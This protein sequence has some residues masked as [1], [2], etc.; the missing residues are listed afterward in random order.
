MVNPVLLVVAPRFGQLQ[1]ER[2]FE[3][4][5]RSCEAPEQHFVLTEIPS[6]QLRSPEQRVVFIALGLCRQIVDHRVHG[7]HGLREHRIGPLCAVDHAEITVFRIP[8]PGFFQVVVGIFVPRNAD[9]TRDGCSG[10]DIR[11]VPDGAL[12]LRLDRRQSPHGVRMAGIG[13]T[14]R[15]FGGH[16]G[17]AREGMDGRHHREHLDRQA[18]RI[19]A[20]EVHADYVAVFTHGGENA[21]F[22]KRRVDHADAQVQVLWSDGAGGIR[23]HREGAVCQGAHPGVFQAGHRGRVAQHQSQVVYGRHAVDP[24]VHCQGL[25]PV[26][27][28]RARDLDKGRS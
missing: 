23:C 3:R 26:R 5:V 22:R 12:G 6:G 2:V 27:I 4:E 16:G 8:V 20:V 25:R 14:E 13:A 17:P 18:V 11:Q 24:P 15:E 19:H 1:R 28:I 7:A 9:M 21:R 10:G